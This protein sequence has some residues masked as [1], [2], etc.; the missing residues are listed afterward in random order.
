MI[1]LY[2]S[3]MVRVVPAQ[4]G[5]TM[6]KPDERVR[7]VILLIEDEPAVARLTELVLDSAGYAVERAS[8]HATALALITQHSYDLIV[9]DTDRGQRTTSLADAKPLL[10]AARCPVLLF[11]AHRFPAAEIAAAGFRGMIR[12][13]F[14]IDDFLNVVKVTLQQSLPVTAV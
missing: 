6:S 10:A 11:S 1:W 2:F 14:D 3:T 12:K 4:A 13:P 8:D 7:P 9:A 5:T